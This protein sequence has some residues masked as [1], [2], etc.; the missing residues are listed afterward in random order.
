M[1]LSIVEDSQ[2][3]LFEYVGRVS[4]LHSLH[5]ILFRSTYCLNTNY[6]LNIVP[7]AFRTPHDART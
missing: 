1:E 2:R 7:Y 6:T 4:V 3:Q 5:I